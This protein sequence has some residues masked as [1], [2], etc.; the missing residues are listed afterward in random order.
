MKATI[1]V[2]ALIA[3]FVRLIPHRKAHCSREIPENAI[4]LG[5]DC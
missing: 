5:A 3:E 4:G 2:R 1:G